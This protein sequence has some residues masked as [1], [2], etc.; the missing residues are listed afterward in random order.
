MVHDIAAV[1]LFVGGAIYC[2]IQSIM[3]YHLF[4]IELNSLYLLIIRLVCSS[5]LAIGVGVFFIAEVF[6]YN[7][8]VESG[9]T[10]TV[11]QWQPEDGGYSLHVLSN[12]AEWLSVWCFGIFVLTYCK[13]FQKIS[14]GIQCVAKSQ[15]RKTSK[16]IT[17]Y[18]SIK[19]ASD[20]EEES[21]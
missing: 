13:E 11:S 5:L 2:W 3:T 19:S 1:F 20:E 16:H 14:I 7:E 9:T 10:H 8:F 6:A 12:M 21:G 18:S 4:K 17:R 15:V